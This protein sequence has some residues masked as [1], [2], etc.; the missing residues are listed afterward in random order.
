MINFVLT[1]YIALMAIFSSSALVGMESKK[2]LIATA[3]TLDLKSE[4]GYSNPAQ[5]GDYLQRLQKLA[6][7]LAHQHRFIGSLDSFSITMSK[8][9]DVQKVSLQL[10]NNAWIKEEGF[11]GAR[12]FFSCTMPESIN[13]VL[14][15]KKLFKAFPLTADQA[16]LEH[17][18]QSISERAKLIFKD[19][20]MQALADTWAESSNS[21]VSHLGKI[22]KTNQL[23][24]A[25]GASNKKNMNVLVPFIRQPNPFSYLLQF[26]S[27]ENY[28]IRHALRYFIN[29]HDTFADYC[30]MLLSEKQKNTLTELQ[31]DK[32]IVALSAMQQLAQGYF[33]NSD[34][35]IELYK[36]ILQEI[37]SIIQQERAKGNKN[38]RELYNFTKELTFDNKIRN[39][40]LNGPLPEHLE[41]IKFAPEVQ[42]TPSSSPDLAQKNKKNVRKKKNVQQSKSS[43]KNEQPEIVTNKN[44]LIEETEDCLK[45]QDPDNK[46]A[47]Q[48]FKTDES[49]QIKMLPVINYT[50]WVVA[51]FN[52]ADEALNAQGYTDPTNKK[53]TPIQ[54]RAHVKAMHGF[55]RLVD[56][57][58]KQWGKQSTTPSRR[59]TNKMDILITLPGALVYQNGTWETGLFTYIIDS[60]NGEWYH[61]NFTTRAGK[62][63]IEDYWQKGYF[64]VEFPPLQ[65]TV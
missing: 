46:L 64:D 27:D 25:L 48:I 15:Y 8:L 45:I 38:F 7:G 56:D 6:N 39:Y 42:D 59:K 28:Y 63:L 5:L 50:D 24:F 36:A 14:K 21:E 4:L 30:E 26:V 55:S 61:R 10:H 32:D 65:L 13:L 19:P 40:I 49:N 62:Q 18:Y 35:F 53:F 37:Q 52:N 16:E 22:L 17:Y 60:E 3:S 44:P 51:W 47:I 12:S 31:T 58:I 1:L 41:F 33:K 34:H 57:Y 11:E 2:E 9:F 29:G 23:I 20:K 43:G 54:D